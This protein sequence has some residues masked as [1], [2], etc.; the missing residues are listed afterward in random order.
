MGRVYVRY[1][2]PNEVLKQVVPAGDNTL[3]AVIKELMDTEERPLG[4]VH[5][6][7]PGGDIR[8]YE[9]WIYEGEIP[10]PPDADP[11]VERNAR[12]RKLVF[13]FVDEQ[14]TGDYRLRYST[15]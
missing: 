15:E 2:E 7:G 11:K 13:L 8:P 1:G 3:L 10:V 14:G 9:V 6:K 4:E 5:Q 12:H